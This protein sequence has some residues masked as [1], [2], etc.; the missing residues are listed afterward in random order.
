MAITGC[1]LQNVTAGKGL[2]GPGLRQAG[3]MIDLDY[4]SFLIDPE[5]DAVPPGARVGE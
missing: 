5:E 1:E 4:L 3:D 2:D